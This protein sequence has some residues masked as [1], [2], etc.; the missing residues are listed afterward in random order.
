MATKRA[1]SKTPKQS[2]PRDKNGRGVTSR[3]KNG[4]D[5]Q[6]SSPVSR[7]KKALIV[8]LNQTL[9]NVTKACSAVGIHKS[10]FY[11]YIRDDPEF[12]AAVKEVD[13]VC[14]DYAVDTLFKQMNAGN[15]K[16]TIFYLE[17]KGRAR[18]FGETPIDV[19]VNITEDAKRQAVAI[20]VMEELRQRLGWTQEAA[21]AFVAE[22][23]GHN[24]LPPAPGGNSSGDVVEG[25]LVN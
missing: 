1:S 12:A 16:A 21:A 17:K 24:A 23:Y 3:P 4:G 11:N 6:I 14:L 10:T 8:A 7:T 18:G 5:S 20:A 15:A 25:E 2:V 22:K 19:N 13:E 9:G